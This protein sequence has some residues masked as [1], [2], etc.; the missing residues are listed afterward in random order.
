MFFVSLGETGS[1]LADG[2]YIVICPAHFDL[3]IHFDMIIA[4]ELIQL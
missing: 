3:T 2:F 1:A 4:T